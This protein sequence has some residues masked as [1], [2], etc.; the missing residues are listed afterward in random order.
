MATLTFRRIHSWNILS[1]VG[2]IQ[3]FADAA[4]LRSV[5]FDRLGREESHL[6]LDLSELVYIGS[7]GIGVMAQVQQD[8]EKRGRSLVLIG[9]N[10]AVRHL[11]EIVS[12][13]RVVL[14][15]DDVDGLAS[16]PA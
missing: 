4:T 14:F 5:L 3:T 9:A 12:L 1:L 6:A 13:D 7:S 8:L 11:L 15:V 16:L 10:A 2:E